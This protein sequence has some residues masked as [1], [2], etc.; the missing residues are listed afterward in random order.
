M[1]QIHYKLRNAVTPRGTSTLK[2]AE[3]GSGLH[4]SAKIAKSA[5][6]LIFTLSPLLFLRKII[7]SEGVIGLS[8]D[9]DLPAFSEMWLAYPITSY[10][11]SKRVFL[12]IFLIGLSQIGLQIDTLS[13][14]FLYLAIFMSFLGAYMLCRKMG[15]GTLPSSFGAFLYGC[16]PPLLFRI[17]AGHL[18]Y[19]SSYSIAPLAVMFFLRSTNRKGK[20]LFN[21]LMSGLLFGISIVQVQ[22]AIMILLVMLLMSL[23][24]KQKISYLKM[25]ILTGFI[26]LITNASWVL[27]ELFTG[28]TRTLTGLVASQLHTAQAV[29]QFSPSF[30]ESLFMQS[31]QGLANYY[32]MLA[33]STNF[34]WFLIP[35]LWSLS[36]SLLFLGT[37]LHQSSKTFRTRPFVFSLITLTGIFLSKGAS[38]PCGSLFLFILNNVPYFISFRESYKFSFITALGYSLLLAHIVDSV[39]SQKSLERVC[40]IFWRVPALARPRLI[41]GLM[42]AILVLLP[43]A[44]PFVNLGDGLQPYKLSDDYRI[45]YQQFLHDKEQYS[46]LWL[47]AVQPFKYDGLAMYGTDPLIAYS[48]KP[49]AINQYDANSPQLFLISSLVQRRDAFLPYTILNFMNVKKIVQR[50]DFVSMFPYYTYMTR[51]NSML[52]QWK[53]EVMFEVCRSQRGLEITQEMNKFRIFTN[54]ALGPRVYVAHDLAILTGGYDSTTTLSYAA[55]VW[56]RHDGMMFAL[57]TTAEAAQTASTVVVNGNTLIDLTS[58]F[59]PDAVAIDPGEFMIS[60]N[61]AKLGWVKA[62]DW[63]WYDWRVVAQFGEGALTLSEGQLDIPFDAPESN[64]YVIAIKTLSLANQPPLQVS[65]DNTLYEDLEGCAQGFE[66]LLLRGVYLQKGVHK[67]GIRARI[68][69]EYYVGRIFILT[70]SSFDSARRVTRDYLAGRNVVLLQEL[71]EFSHVDGDKLSSLDIELSQGE[72]FTA[73]RFQSRTWKVEIPIEGKYSIFIRASSGVEFERSGLNIEVKGQASNKMGWYDLGESIFK[74]G[75]I[76]LMFSFD[77]DVQL[78]MLA[79]IRQQPLET[80]SEFDTSNSLTS[81]LSENVITCSYE[82][83]RPSIVIVKGGVSEGWRL[84]Q[85]AENLESFIVDIGSIA[86]KVPT[87]IG[88]FELIRDSPPIS[89]AL[90]TPIAT[91][92]LCVSIITVYIR[93]KKEGHKDRTGE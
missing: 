46:I 55:P 45:L 78:D 11:I 14:A 32:K 69:G 30:F 61:D 90:A 15:Y 64:T 2:H 34:P 84:S 26:A 21:I 67:V 89:I 79:L 59:S 85:R 81:D 72:A 57:Q 56:N 68:G 6:V 83:D 66:Y 9:W 13:K 70:E 77:T 91:F 43:A 41:L 20:S 44:V 23:L 53:N 93:Q 4:T 88:R 22:F 33:L 92:L 71:E 1:N 54:V 16:S 40:S 76:N 36:I 47:P 19:I 82:F 58:R 73:K 80:L 50:D 10:L 7:Y 25:V 5:L 27:W 51:Y 65:I 12:N 49:S 35:I 87:G 52:N 31:G 48:P 74:E 24:A 29:K 62:R 3:A 38:D 39:I 17:L 18:A 63:W 75:M 28:G 8:H 60:L 42:I 37:L 86:V